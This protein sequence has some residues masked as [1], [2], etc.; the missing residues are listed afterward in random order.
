LNFERMSSQ[1][2]SGKKLPKEL[3]D[4]RSLSE[5]SIFGNCRSLNTFLGLLDMVLLHRYL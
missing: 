1:P 3:G 2:F 4:S 5:D